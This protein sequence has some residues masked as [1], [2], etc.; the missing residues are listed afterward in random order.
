MGS[1]LE[2]RGIRAVTLWSARALLEAPNAVLK[3][4]RENVAAGAEILTS[5]TFRTSRVTLAKA[6]IGELAEEL[7]KLAVDMARKAANEALHTVWIAGSIAPLHDCYRP[8][9]VADD[10]TLAEEH[11]RHAANLAEFGADLLLVET[12][13][14]VKELLAAT[15]AAVATGLPTVASVV[16]GG[17]GRL[18][19]GE[20]LAE[21][22][23]A[24]APLG[25]A[26][27]GVNC[28][29]SARIG[30]EIAR[31]HTAVNPMPLA[32]YGNTLSDGD[33]PEAYAGRAA[34]WV[35][36]GAQIVGGCCGTGAAHIA[37][38]KKALRS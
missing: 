4:H 20:M 37:A 22:G 35:A 29:S 26:A 11:A 17:W 38:L 13:N 27:I 36:S 19:S 10:K 28:V 24:V 23:Q 9:L 1:E 31:L 16:T 32:V 15:R 33:S 5:N 34:G 3:I 12:M 6:G 25:P 30:E 21:A 2:R 14:S 18:L 8:D 7:T